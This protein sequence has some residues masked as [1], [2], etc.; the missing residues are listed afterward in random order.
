MCLWVLL[1]GQCA[2]VACSELWPQQFVCDVDKCRIMSP[3]NVSCSVSPRSTCTGERTIERM[4]DCIYCWQLPESSL[5]CFFSGVQCKPGPRPQAA[6]CNVLP[7]VSC[8]GNR[9][10]TKQ[11]YCE[12]TSGLSYL[13]AIC[14]SFFFGGLGADRFY[15][16]YT[17]AGFVKM[18]TLGGFGVWSILDLILLLCGALNPMD[19]TLFKEKVRA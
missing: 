8:L 17:M 1:A 4:I 6:T 3:V 11:M 15:L 12:S 19:G 16:G 9:T 10:F 13:T 2:S 18:F 14:L 7:T 5:R